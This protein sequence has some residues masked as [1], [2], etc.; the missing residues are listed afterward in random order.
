MPLKPLKK[1]LKK[2][3]SYDFQLY[4]VPDTLLGAVTDE[5][6]Q[7]VKAKPV[8]RPWSK[9]KLKAKCDT[10]NNTTVD[11]VDRTSDTTNADSSQQPA[12]HKKPQPVPPLPR[13]PMSKYV[14]LSKPP[15]EVNEGHRYVNSNPNTALN[16]P[17]TSTE[18]IECPP[19]P[20][21]PAFPPPP[22]SNCIYKP[23]STVRP[24]PEIFN[25]GSW[26]SRS[27]SA[28]FS[29]EEV[30]LYCTPDHS[31]D[32][33]YPDRPAVPA[34]QPT[35]P[36]STGP[37]L[38]PFRPPPTR[39]L[40]PES[41]NT[42]HPDLPVLPDTDEHMTDIT[43]MLRWLQRESKSH[44]MAPSF[45]GLSL[46]EEIRSFN[47]R[48]MNVKKALRLYN[49]LLMKRK[50]TLQ[51][52]ITEFNSIC[53]SLDKVQKKTQ[54]IESAGVVAIIVGVAMVPFTLG[55]SLIA[56]AV[57]VGMVLGANAKAKKKSVNKARVETLAFQYINEVGDLERC[58][59][60]ILSGMDFILSGMD[61]LRRHD[62]PRLQRARVQADAVNMAHL[63]KYVLTNNARKGSAN[64]RLASPEKLLKTFIHE[65]DQYFTK[66]GGQKLKKSNESK[67]SG[68]VHLLA[69]NLQDDLDHMNSLWETFELYV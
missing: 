62:L 12:D 3:S 9:I 1:S 65:L 48:A 51:E 24:E 13:P 29:V 63:S 34:W 28:A 16:P 22:P 46:E 50:E 5:T 54:K 4:E 37:P 23:L 39:T 53:R 15:A 8:P 31:T 59:D 42:V 26:Q 55:L 56:T 69:E 47:E 61:E 38:P 20:P 19:P 68:R 30:G 43:M 44:L 10:S 11:S 7:E 58:L 67:F 6:Q 17:A 33:Y 45:Y 36:L 27:S 21:R 41:E 14:N 49:L 18:T 52:I 66:K 2:S 57:G 35:L 40:Q 25:D 64:T 32:S 60:F